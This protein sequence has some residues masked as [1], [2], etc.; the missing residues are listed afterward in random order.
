[1]SVLDKHMVVTM[2]DKSEWAVP[3]RVIAENRAAAYA[4]EF[5]GDTARSLKEDTAPLFEAEDYEIR[6][7]AA[8]N[9]NWEDV[10]PY[11]NELPR[12]PNAVDYQ[13]GWVNG[14]KRVVSF[15][16]VAP[17]LR[18]IE[19]FPRDERYTRPDAILTMLSDRY[20]IGDTVLRVDVQASTAGC[21]D[22][23]HDYQL[24]ADEAPVFIWRTP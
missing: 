14:P 17:R 13:E 9:M 15:A 21:F 11:A 4:D 7:W 19:V 20:H 16:V 10:K 5:D 2:P 3:V 6:D 22:I 8:N 24:T 18:E 12:K 23:A 1:M